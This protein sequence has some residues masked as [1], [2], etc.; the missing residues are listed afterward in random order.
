MSRTSVVDKSAL[1][2]GASSGIGRAIAIELARRGAHVVLVARRRERLDEVLSQIVALGRTGE[3]HVADL[4]Q[5]SDRARLIERYLTAP[6]IDILVNNAGIGANGRFA[7]MDPQRIDAMFAVNVAAPMEL[8]HAFA[9]AARKRRSGAILNVASVAAATPTPFHALYAS[10]KALFS[11][12]SHAV[13]PELARSG[14]V[15]ACLWPGLTDTEF[16]TAGRYNLKSRVYRGQRM[17][18][19]ETAVIA[20]DGLLRGTERIIPGWSAKIAAFLAGM[21]PLRIAARI[22][23]KVMSTDENPP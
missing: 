8:S 19:E 15:V 22:A 21:T 17:N 12:F 10:T 18:P 9:R 23:G 4:S 6:S 16:F 5:K 1:V 13:L 14:I 7:E 3:I 11:S 20:V 2:T